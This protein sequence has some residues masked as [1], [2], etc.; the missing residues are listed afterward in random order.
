MRNNEL[1]DPSVNL[2]PQ[3]SKLRKNGINGTWSGTLKAYTLDWYFCSVAHKGLYDIA[4]SWPLENN[5]K[6]E[7][8][9]LKSP[10]QKGAVGNQTSLLARL[11][12]NSLPFASHWKTL[13]L[14]DFWFTHI[15]HF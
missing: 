15:F 8:G 13:Y 3:I 12:L 11:V 4:N 10:L 7:Q 14:A 9:K 1:W 6:R 2:D 5:L